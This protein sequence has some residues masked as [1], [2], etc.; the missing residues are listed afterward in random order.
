[1][2]AIKVSKGYG[3]DGTYKY[4]GFEIKVELDDYSESPDDWGDDE[5]YLVADHREF[6]VRSEC[7]DDVRNKIC[8]TKRMFY[9]GYYVFPVD[10]Y[11]HSG[12]ALSFSGFSQDYGGWDTSSG[13]CFILI[14]RVR[15]CWSRAAAYNA[16][17]SLLGCWNMYLSGDVHV[18]FT[19]GVDYCVGG[20]YGTDGI[21]EAISEAEDAI[22]N[23]IINNC[24]KHIRKI[25]QQ[26]KNHAPLSVRKEWMY[27]KKNIV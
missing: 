6:S 26:I 4:R 2:K 12:I 14:K 24:K 18:C 21:E 11:I 20:R 19:D 7:I 23:Y 9:N 15:E 25:K 22:D 13:W 10:I 16:A 3:D 5:R 27:G 1:M 17:C 8:E